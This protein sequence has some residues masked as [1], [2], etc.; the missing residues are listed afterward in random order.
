MGTRAAPLH[1]FHLGRETMTPPC[2]TSQEPPRGDSDR[3]LLQ[4]SAPQAA[5]MPPWLP[6][7]HLQTHPPAPPNPSGGGHSTSWSIMSP[8]SYM[9]QCPPPELLS[10]HCK[11]PYVPFL[12]RHG[13]VC[14]APFYRKW[15]YSPPIFG[16]GLG[17][18]V[19]QFYTPL[20]PFTPTPGKVDAA[21]YSQCLAQLGY[22]QGGGCTS[23]Q[24]HA[25][26]PSTMHH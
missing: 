2:I 4:T 25:P 16:S 7:P 13:G 24:H 12:G 5:P 21:P 3:R 9:I 11:A 26:A 22:R 6:P 18:P 17:C 15:G 8:G 23:A 20:G 19:G 10:S 14:A 1:Q